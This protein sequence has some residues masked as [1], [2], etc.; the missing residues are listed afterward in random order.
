VKSLVRA[1]A[2]GRLAPVA[3]SE[4]RLDLSRPSGLRASGF[5]LTAAGALV[6]GVGALLVWITVGIP[7]ES[8]HTSLRGTDLGDGDGRV[9]FVCAFLILISLVVSRLVRSRRH[10][11]LL[12]ALGLTSGI[13]AVLIAADFIAGGKDRQP[14]LQALGIPRAMWAQLGAFRDLGLGPYLV[15]AGG[16]FCI[17]GALLTLWWARRTE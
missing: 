1:R 5:L 7:N 12:A 2:D 8:A 13:V 9:A 16:V 4:P 15:L 14:V 6:I 17:A 11:Q 10:R 3:E